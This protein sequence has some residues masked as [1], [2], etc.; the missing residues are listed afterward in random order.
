M[1]DVYYLL[2]KHCGRKGLGFSNPN[3]FCFL[4]QQFYLLFNIEP[5]WNVLSKHRFCFFLFSHNHRGWKHLTWDDEQF[6]V[7]FHSSR[8]C[9][10]IN[11]YWTMYHK[12]NNAISCW[13]CQLTETVFAVCPL[14]FRKCAH[15]W[16]HHEPF[17]RMKG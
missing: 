16:G 7:L 15:P 12:L 5:G 13:A 17:F 3:V 11:K 10:F 6:N 4:R 8:I 14:G 1:C 9:L 2:K